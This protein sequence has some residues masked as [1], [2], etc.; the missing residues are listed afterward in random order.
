LTVE[1]DPV[2][3]ERDIMKLLP[4][5]EWTM[6]SHRLIFHGRQVCY[7]RKPNC[8]GCGLAGL[9]PKIGV[10]GPAKTAVKPAKKPGERRAGP[11]GKREIT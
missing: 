6:F 10:E 5:A 11:L 7:A 8:A 4:P 9:C 1:T 3:V 2:K